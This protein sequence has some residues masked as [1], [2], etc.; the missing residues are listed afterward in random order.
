MHDVLCGR[1]TEDRRSDG[2]FHHGYAVSGHQEALNQALI[3]MMGELP[4][5]EESLS[6]Y[7]Q[8]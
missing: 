8:F 2:H 6:F 7:K 5:L 4:P 3:L 1:E